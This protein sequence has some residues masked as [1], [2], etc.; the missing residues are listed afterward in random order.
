MVENLGIVGGCRPLHSRFS[1]C[2]PTGPAFAVELTAF[3]VAD[4]MDLG[5]FGGAKKPTGSFSY[6]GARPPAGPFCAPS[7]GRTPTP[8]A[9]GKVWGD[10]GQW[11]HFCPV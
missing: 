3:V 11:R 6:L 10:D 7:P 4:L 9:S 2:Q 8:W 5:G 1:S